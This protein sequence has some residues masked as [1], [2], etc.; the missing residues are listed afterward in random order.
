MLNLYQAVFKFETFNKEVFVHLH[1]L[2][3]IIGY[4]DD[5]ITET[6]NKCFNGL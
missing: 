5:K 6:L 4:I 2:C 3:I 1:Q